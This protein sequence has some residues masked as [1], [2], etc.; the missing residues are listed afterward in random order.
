MYCIMVLYIFFFIFPYQQAKLD[1]LVFLHNWKHVNSGL[2]ISLIPYHKFN[3]Y[4]NRCLNFG[5]SGLRSTL[6]LKDFYFS[7]YMFLYLISINLE[8]CI[9]D[10]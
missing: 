5:I 1:A 3:I 4:L 9:F 6:V 10:I 7:K 2:F 8:A